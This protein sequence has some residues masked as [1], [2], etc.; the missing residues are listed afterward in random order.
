[1]TTRFLVIALALFLTA[2][3]ALTASGVRVIDGDTLDLDGVRYRLHGI[4]APEAGQTCKSA[5]GGDWPCGQAALHKLESL[6]TG[7]NPTC[8]TREKDVYGRSIA[9]CKIDGLDISSEMIRSGLAWAFRRYSMDY[10][11]A[12]EAAHAR[13][14][15]IWQADT[16]PAWD[17]RSHKWDG[18]ASGG[19][20]TGCPIKGNINSKHEK[21]YH[22]PWSK[23]YARTSIDPGRGERW[24]CTEGEAVA[25]GWRP[26]HGGR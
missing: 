15:G 5:K 21:I 14:V 10:I 16:E 7:R 3:Q 4:D 23:D 9:T 2:G 1:M 25:A 24:F 11:P 12:E 13:R 22:A 8:V 17:F 6:T 18:A 20:V 26:P 19:P